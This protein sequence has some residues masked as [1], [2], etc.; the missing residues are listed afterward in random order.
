MYISINTAELYELLQITP[1]NQ[2]IMLVGKH[3][4][5]KSEIIKK[6]YEDLGLVTVSF[7]LGQMSDPGDLI[8]LMHKKEDNK[9]V[10]FLPP[11]WWP[12]DNKPVVLFL[13]ELNRAR[14]ELLQTVMDLVLNKTLAG[15]KLPN[16]S[17]IVAAINEGDEY[18]LTELDPAL[19]S[20]FNIYNFKP[21]VNEWIEWANKTSLDERVVEFIDEYNDHLGAF[22]E[23]LSEGSIVKTPD[24]RAWVRV[25]D[26]LKNIPELKPI[27]TKIIAG[28]VGLNSA[29]QFVEFINNNKFSIKDFLF[30][31]DNY[32]PQI[33]NYDIVKLS[34]LNNKIAHFLK[35]YTELESNKKLIIK[36]LDKY[37]KYLDSK[38]MKEAIAH[39]VALL[40]NKD[41]AI[42]NLLVFKDSGYLSKYITSFIINI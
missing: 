21:T 40:E 1:T 8:G 9:K 25:S 33:A 30:D 12:I 39:F 32:L 2:S 3:G 10:D 15:K 35:S 41:N 4:I 14:Q 6:Y 18:Q 19:I 29:Y 17:I 27:H 37:I 13:D 5:G 38:Q 26:L 31:F 23:D 34:K 24:R 28:I 20:R 36:N 7:F 16:D 22:I 11:Y 42:L